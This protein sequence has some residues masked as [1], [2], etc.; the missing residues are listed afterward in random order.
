[1][2]KRYL[3]FLEK[4]KNCYGVYSPDVPGCISTGQTLE[5]AK[6]NM[7][8]ALTLHLDGLHAYGDEIPENSDQSCYLEFDWTP[9]RLERKDQEK[10]PGV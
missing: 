5:E 7:V 6:N 4:G 10:S 8:K 1:M 2:K 3:V 9:T